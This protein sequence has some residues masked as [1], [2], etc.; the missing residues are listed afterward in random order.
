MGEGGRAGS[1]T[2]TDKSPSHSKFS[3]TSPALCALILPVFDAATAPAE[4]RNPDPTDRALPPCV[5]KFLWFLHTFVAYGRNLADTLRRH[6][7]DPR[8]LPWFT[9]VALTFRSADLAVILARISRGL[10]RA[11]AL[12][13]RLRKLAARGQDLDSDRIRPSS[14]RKP[15]PRKKPAPRLHDAIR[16]PSLDAPPTLEQIAAEDRHRPIGAVLVDVCLDLGIVPARMD[17]AAPEELRRAVIF[18]GGSLVALYATRLRKSGDLAT[19]LSD[20]PL[21]IDKDGRPTIAHPPWPG[22]PELPLPLREK[23]IDGARGPGP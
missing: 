2:L 22:S 16:A 9:D 19:L 20:L 10:L 15:R 5:G 23:R 7:A 8:V 17:R 12:E 21:P 1:I 18:Y 13:E 11:A 4:A 3:L 14:P 6:A